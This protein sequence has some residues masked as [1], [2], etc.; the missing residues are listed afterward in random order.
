MRPGPHRVEQA[1]VEAPKH[2]PQ[3]KDW[4]PGPISTIGVAE[5]RTGRWCRAIGTCPAT[6]AARPRCATCSPSTGSR[7]PRRWRSG[8]APG[9]ASTTSR[10]TANRR[11]GSPTGASAGSRSS[12]CELTGRR[13]ALRDLRASR[14]NHGR[15]RARTVDAGPAGAA[16]HRPLLPRPLRALGP[17][18]GPRGGARRLRRRGRLA[19][20]HRLRG[21]ADD[22]AR[23]PRGG[24][25]RASSRCSRSTATCSTCP[26]ARAEPRRPARARGPRRSSERAAR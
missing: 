20:R 14:R 25:P 12:S 21:P 17:F 8:S 19:L 1:A 15:R 18:P 11:R 6:T 7:S 23:E 4:L 26:R 2:G 22:L 9:S 13:C 3:N 5:P 24:P 10:S 16:A